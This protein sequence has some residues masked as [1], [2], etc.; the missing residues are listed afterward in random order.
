MNQCFYVTEST[1]EGSQCTLPIRH[2]PREGPLPLS[3]AQQRL[4]FLDQWESDNSA[5]TLPIAVRLDGRLN[6]TALEQ[7]FGEITRRHEV[8]RTIFAAADGRPVQIVAPSLTITLP[9]V[10][11]QC[12]EKVELATVVERLVAEEAQRPF[13]LTQLPLF[14]ATLLQ[15]GA[16]EHVLLLTMHT[17]ICD[18]C[19]VRILLR[20]MMMCYQAYTTGTLPPVAE[21]PIQYADF[22]VWQRL[23]LRGAESKAQLAYWKQRLGNDLPVLELPTDHPR[24]AAQT[25]RGATR[26]FVLSETLSKSLKT[27]SAQENVPLLVTLLAAFKVL[28]WR[29]TQ[30]DDVALGLPVAN[31]NWSEIVGLIGHFANTLVIRTDLSGNPGFRVLLDRVRETTMGARAHQD[32]P[33]EV[34]VDELQPERDPGRPPLFQVMFDFEDVPVEILTGTD[35]SLSQLEVDSKTAAFDLTL[36]MSDAE[37]GLKGV[38]EYNT[39]LFNADTIDRM[40]G[41]F[42]T[43][44]EG[45]TAHSEARIAD[46]PL[47]TVGERRQLLAEWNDTETL[48]PQERCI[49][50]LFEG[51][52]ERAP[53][54]IAVVF[55]D[56]HLSYEELN[57][58]A[59]QLA[60]RL[61]RL[62]VGPEVLVG[63]C[64]ERSVEMVVATLGI[65]KAGGAYVPLDPA[66][67][68]ERLTFMIED[69]Q[70]PVLLVQRRLL[71]NLP[72]GLD[73]D[74]LCLDSDWETFTRESTAN[75][76]THTTPDSLAY[77]MYT[78]G[79]TG[80][81]KGT[82]IVHR[83]VVRL[84]QETDYA[85]L[86]SDQVF[87]QLAPISFDASTLEVWGSLLNGARLVVFPPHTPSLEDVGRVVQQHQVTTLWL[88][89]GLFHLMVNEQ[90]E[91]LENVRQLLAGGDVLSVSHVHRV[92]K[93]LNATRLINGYGPTEN[94]TF[95]TC[96]PMGPDT[97]IPTSVPIG[98]PIANTQI[99]ILDNHSWPVPVGVPGELYVGGDGLARDYLNRPALTAQVFVPNPFPPSAPLAE[100][101]RGGGRLYRTGDLARYLPDGNVEFLGRIDHQ[102]K[103]RG[104]RVEL[105]EIEAVVEQHP[106]V[107][108]TVVLARE[109]NPGDKRLVAYI[110]T[111]EGLQPSVDELRRFL[112]EKLPAYM[113][114]SVYVALDALP[115]TPNNK[116]DR[117]ALPAPEGARLEVESAFVSPRTP[118]E[119]IVAEMWS[120]VLG[121]ERVGIHDNFFA[122]GG[123]SLL[124]TQVISRMQDAFQVELALHTMFGM[125]TVASLAKYVEMAMDSERLQSL[126]IGRVS[127]KGP[128]PLSFT[129]QQLWL[130]DQLKPGNIAYNIPF[131]LRMS[132]PL[133]VTALQR[134]L[135]EIVCRHKALRTTITTVDGRLVQDIAP[136]LK[137]HLPLVDLCQLPEIERD[138]K[139]YHLA[140]R[141]AQRV[142]D[143]S[144]GPLIRVT[145]LRLEETE[146]L[147]LLMMHH[148]VT[149]GWSMGIF[150][151]ELTT[152]YQAFTTDQPSSLPDLAIQYADF[153]IWQRQYLQGEVLEALLSF[154]RQQLD[155]APALLK[156]PTDRPRPPAQTFRGARQS[157]VLPKSLSE[158]LKALS[159]RE[160]VTLFITLLAAF[161]A[162][163]Y[164]YTGQSD[165]VVGSP[166]ANRSQLEVESLIGYFVNTLALRTSLAE[167][168]TFRELLARVRHVA[169][170]A[171]T[172][173]DLPFEKLV[174]VL[175]PK[176]DLGYN[177]L[178]QTMFTFQNTPQVAYSLP[179]LTISP[180]EIDAG[181]SLFDLRLEI[182][183]EDQVLAGFVEYNTD[184][185]D[186]ATITEMLEH[187]QML[188]ESAVANPD[189]S[190]STLVSSIRFE[191]CQ[192]LDGDEPKSHR[193]LVLPRG[194]GKDSIALRKARLSTERARLTAEQRALFEKRLR[195]E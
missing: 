46:I 154:W 186:D 69:T 190:L 109:D 4:W 105:G 95:T 111:S 174:E 187:Y 70:S 96:Y 182:A 56:Q 94:T 152:L 63:L 78:S 84:V 100:G 19:S 3:F 156:L 86:T 110:V 146:H 153:A 18:A 27:L 57:R 119:E 165:I 179:N 135:D 137:L 87:V 128:P 125:P 93:E 164:R 193:D 117:R 126:P 13:D 22:A 59:N 169:V 161:K 72:P 1:G 51:Q 136:S 138:A 118:V 16:E 50:E 133:D 65:I 9:L 66:Y 5:H 191:R 97:Q 23:W 37:Q 141:E 127:Q 131:V 140:R 45:I 32:V 103:I 91:T 60:H 10:N 40:V 167:N 62:G 192:P 14:R 180:M 39:D 64:A 35:L 89:A 55:Q 183:E 73:T 99:Y 145:L 6:M 38:F 181:T 28:L 47:L 171:Y 80:R 79:S 76:V 61:Q 195:G 175:Q 17:I 124:A 150:T 58:R 53:D 177:P 142:F 155:G 194:T 176:R 121:I 144:N 188:L 113:M 147:L 108:E 98:R 122:L 44:L 130:I 67:P 88:T 43:L 120:Q 21:L 134:S 31:R 162:L 24:P 106:A 49:H 85:D 178:F 68:Q 77:V 129:Q 54:A 102:V 48:Y 148:I 172:H 26:S 116:V 159:R 25:F 74:I 83:G 189:Q 101:E 75:L 157:L 2:V 123:H 168:P 11:L 29:Y 8:L 160:G 90:L 104:F 158:A 82:C 42:R 163:L 184:L 7:S 15:L 52:V 92:L 81:P 132:G 143:L 33:F 173:S 12:L 71:E 112:Q 139:A 36:S 114:P 185:F 166:I 115:L 149:D 151:R 41:H 170:N 34:L 107:R 30:Q 20:E